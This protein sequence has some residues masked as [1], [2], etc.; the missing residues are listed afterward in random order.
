[1]S[2][3]V[4]EDKNLITNETEYT[5]NRL[6]SS[7]VKSSSINTPLPEWE[8]L[9]KD[10]GGMGRFQIF[11]FIIITLQTNSVGWIIYNLGLITM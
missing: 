8:T 6:R 11:S 2:K 4:D 7:E 3:F 9:I 1:M 5:P 10:Q